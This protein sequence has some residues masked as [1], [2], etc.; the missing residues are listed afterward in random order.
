MHLLQR[1]GPLPAKSCKIIIENVIPT[2]VIL[3]AN[4]TN[5]CSLMK[6]FSNMVNCMQIQRIQETS[7]FF[8][9]PP[10]VFVVKGITCVKFCLKFMKCLMF[11]ASHKLNK[12]S[13]YLYCFSSSNFAFTSLL[14]QKD[15]ITNLVTKNLRK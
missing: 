15:C 10:V 11:M 13:T 6:K 12:H 1:T 2:K 3:I 9:F 8:S 14:P 7:Q 4:R 5:V